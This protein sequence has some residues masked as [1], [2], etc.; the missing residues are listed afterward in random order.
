MNKIYIVILN[1]GES[2]EDFDKWNAGIFL[3]KEQAINFGCNNTYHGFEIEEWEFNKTKCNHS[4]IFSYYL[5][6]WM[7]EINS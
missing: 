7:E 6:K 5:N 4:W 2:Y 3:S 1:N